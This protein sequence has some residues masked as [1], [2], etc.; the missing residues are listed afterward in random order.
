MKKLLLLILSFLSQSTHAQTF[1]VAHDT[2]YGIASVCPW[3]DVI[4]LN[5]IG[6]LTTGPLPI[7]WKVDSSN[8]PCD[9]IPATGIFDYM[10]G[11]TMSGLWSCSSGTL[12]T[13]M[14]N[15][16]PTGGAMEVRFLTSTMM[17]L[18]TYWLRVKLTDTVAAYSRYQ[19][20][21]ITLVD[22]LFPNAGTITGDSEVCSGSTMWLTRSVPGGAWSAMNS[23]AT[24]SAYGMVTAV[25][26]G[27]D[28]IRYGV[29]NSCVTS[30]ATKIITVNALPTPAITAAGTNLSTEPF[31]SSY[32]WYFSGTPIA[33][34]TNNSQYAGANGSYYV[35]VTD[36]N[37]C[38]ANSP[39]V[40]VPLA[41]GNIK[42]SD[43]TI[44]P[45]PAHD[46]I[47]ITGIQSNT[48]YKIVSIAGITVLEGTLFH[49]DVINISQIPSGMYILV[50][51]TDE[52]G[53]C[54]RRF[55]KY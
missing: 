33:A 32:Q 3:T 30:Y 14:Q 35:Q 9:W 43:L 40:N 21:I 29:S 34:G 7:R 51:G 39:T 12:T 44:L 53:T 55:A 28:T 26:A 20:F 6:N 2:M 19:T 17:T 4:L 22:T 42:L 27:I 1:T 38:T 18:G 49:N 52:R 46:H 48:S 36:S 23:S 5:P 10:A 50:V 25:S 54:F 15:V 37:G 13:I 47:A 41:V 8:F 45:N 11:Y 31:Y 24:V 16:P